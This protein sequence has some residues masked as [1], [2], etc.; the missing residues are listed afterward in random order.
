MNYAVPLSSGEYIGLI[1]DEAVYGFN[2]SAE[3]Y[4]QSFSCAE[5]LLPKLHLSVKQGERLQLHWHQGDDLARNKRI[6][7]PLSFELCFES[8]LK[9]IKSFPVPKQG[10]FNQ[11]LGRK[12]KI[13]LDATGGWGNDAIL[14]AIQGYQVLVQERHPLMA[15]LL[16]DAFD[17]FKLA[18]AKE[19]Y[20]IVAPSVMLVNSV[21]AWPD[22][23]LPID[24]VYLDPMFPPKR[25]KS[26]ATN[27][28]MQLLQWLL[29]E[30]QDAD[31]LLQTTLKN[32]VPR[33][34][35]KRPDYAEPLLR[36]PDQQFSSKL[37]HYDVYLN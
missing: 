20:P 16:A 3:R 10:A 18:V 7:K 31:A 29:G 22:Y 23:D 5:G 13:V 33:V 24:C 28:Q 12:T 2:A 37:V 6:P 21:A 8:Q 36:N 11:A 15:L 4:L 19:A 1:V 35:V 26:A 14:M 25:K 34:S 27:K 17:R 9:S 32:G 30:D